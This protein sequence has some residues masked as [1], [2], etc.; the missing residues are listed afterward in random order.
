MNQFN[1]LM[2]RYVLCMFGDLLA[3]LLLIGQAP[4]IGFA[5]AM[6]LGAME[7][8]SPSIYFMMILAA[9][10]FGCINSCREIVK[11][12]PIVERERLFGLSM[13]AY[14]SSRFAVLAI[15][16]LLQSLLLQITVEW[17]MTLKGAFLLQTLALWGASLCG[18]GLGL[19]V[20]AFATTQERAVFF[21][22]LLLIPQII[23]SQ[24]V[25]PKEYFNDIINI[26]E[27]CMPAHWAYEVFAES[28]SLSPK[29]GWL[30]LD[31]LVLYSFAILLIM[32]AILGMKR[33]V[34]Y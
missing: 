4:I 19:I 18:I 6:V 13:P 32:I 26:A 27:K 5:L 22:P 24:F 31:I 17:N 14:I 8:D 15:L 16:G 30:V 9:L 2:E 25:I 7:H 3:L 11:E 21:I 34:E 29:W 23:F 10:W 12:R 28:A 20:S 33:R 1:I